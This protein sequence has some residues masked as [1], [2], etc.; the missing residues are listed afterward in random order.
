MASDLITAKGFVFSA[1]LSG[2]VVRLVE[3]RGARVIESFVSLLGPEV[4]ITEFAAMYAPKAVLADAYTFADVPGFDPALVYARP[5]PSSADPTFNVADFFSGN[6]AGREGPT[7]PRELW[8]TEPM[9]EEDFWGLIGVLGGNVNEAGVELLESRLSQLPTSEIEAFARRLY[10]VAD[11]LNTE[12]VAAAALEKPYFGSDAFLWWRLAIIA[13]G[14]AARDGVLAGSFSTGVTEEAWEQ[15][16]GLE[17]VAE[18]AVER[19]DGVRPVFLQAQLKRGATG[20]AGSRK[21]NDVEAAFRAKFGDGTVDLKPGPRTAAAMTARG[22]EPGVVASRFVVRARDCSHECVV[23]QHI[24][25]YRE[26]VERH[27]REGAE[28]IARQLD[29]VV[30]SAIEYDDNQT[31]SL[32]DW[33]AI[34][35][36][37]RSWG[38]SREEYLAAYGLGLAPSC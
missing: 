32:Q 20:R 34:F 35:T 33:W 22:L 7:S 5:I 10:L 23:I 14:P 25:L 24:D 12:E 1:A 21:V 30:S 11:A 31:F 16:G 17:S 36:I 3:Q 26:N 8:A 2:R 37:R 6:L 18:R 15:A 9:A 27:L 28:G 38:G 4:D 13:R 19:R 29:G